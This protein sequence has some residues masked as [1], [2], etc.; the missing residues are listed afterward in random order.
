MTSDRNALRLVAHALGCTDVKPSLRLKQIAEVLL[1]A[2]VDVDG[3]LE[4]FPDLLHVQRIQSIQGWAYLSVDES[5]DA[6][7]I[8]DGQP[9]AI[10][11]LEAVYTKRVH[12]SLMPKGVTP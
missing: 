8:P 11:R 5:E 2:G 3:S 7:A 6:N 1:Q 4:D 12:H 9:V 10:Y